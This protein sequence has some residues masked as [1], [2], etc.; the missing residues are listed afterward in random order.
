MSVDDLAEH[1]ETT[2][3]DLLDKHCAVVKICRKIGPLTSWFDAVCRQSRRYSR[4]LEK[5]YRRTRSDTDRLAWVQQLKTMHALYEEKN[6][7]HWRTKIADSKG[8]I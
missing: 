1:Y 3:S 2:M 6:H 8:N 4:M 5:R 7:Q